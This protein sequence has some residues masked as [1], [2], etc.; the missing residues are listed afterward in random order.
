MKQLL[1]KKD[2]PLETNEEDEIINFITPMGLTF[3]RNN[4]LIGENKARCYGI[5]RYAPTVNYGWL[6]KLTNIPNT[7]ACINYEP[8][9]NS[10]F[11]QNVASSISRNRSDAQN[12]RNAIE[13]KR[14]EKAAKDGDQLIETIDSDNQSIGSVGVQ[15]MPLARED[16]DFEKACMN[17]ET[18]VASISSKARILANIQKESFKSI[19]PYYTKVKSTSEI[20]QR[21]MPMKTFLGGFPF[22]TSGY[23]DG[24]E[25]KYTFAH[26]SMGGLVNLDI[27]KRG[28]DRTN[29]NVTIMG[30][31]GVGK[32][33]TVK[34]LA[35]NEYMM[36]TK[37][38]FIDPE[39]EYVELTKNLN[40]DVINAGGGLNGLINPLQIM[41]SPAV[42]EEDEGLGDL[43]L[44]LQTLDVF[45]S[46]YISDLTDIQKALLKDSVIEVYKNFGIDWDTDVSLFT[47]EDFP[48]MNDLYKLIKEKEKK[49]VLYK[50]LAILLK[51]VA[52]GG[53]RYLFGQHS[54]LKTNSKMICL[55]TSN[56]QNSNDNIKK[57]QY[58]NLLTYAWNI[59]SR[60]RNEKVLL[61][62]D[63][64]YLMIDERVP[65]SLIFLNNA[66]KRA[67]KYEAGIGIISHSVVDFLAPSIKKYGQSL[68]DNPCYKILMGSDGKNLEELKELYSLTDAEESLIASKIRGQ[69]IAM[70]GSS[71]LAVK[72]IIP[73]HKLNLM[74]SA[75]GR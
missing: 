39:G 74:G 52:V 29:S 6:S 37:I 21:V 2:K 53:D 17:T 43:A 23:T 33:A 58:F 70:I 12:A 73:P 66:S 10:A 48:I 47:N 13:Q 18:K 45:F 38:I 25:A 75:G 32:S 57:A 26:D 68:L 24:S 8:I 69:A 42:N 67:R 16:K 36:G 55:N 4:L 15:I 1:K 5:I 44:H 41:K 54:S 64:A 65:Q 46:L 14:A 61:I 35:I 63:E 34:Y 56:L 27:W 40:G 31:P 30:V 50:D 49:D 71:R 22:S 3:N 28:G 9:N 51:D 72:F 60:D 19:A 59:M 20:L 7:V 11:I 62:C